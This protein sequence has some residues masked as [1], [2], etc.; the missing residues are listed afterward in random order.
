MKGPPPSPE[1]TGGEASIR[2]Y[3]PPLRRAGKLRLYLDV[4]TYR[5]RKGASFTEERV[6][7]VGVLEDWTPYAPDSAG[8]WGRVK[9]R[10]FTEWELGSERNVVKEFY[11]YLKGLIRARRGG[12]VKSIEVVGF[13]VLRFDIPLL[14]QKGAEYGV[15]SVAELN[16]LWYD[17][18]TRDL[19]QAA[20]PVNNMRFQGLTLG[21]LASKLR[22]AG[23]NIPE[24]HGKGVDVKDWYEKGKY[25]EIIKHLET[26]L[27]TTRVIDLRYW[28]LF[29]QL[30]GATSSATPGS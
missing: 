24:L 4:E 7:A 2:Y 3:C 8:E 21:Y 29:E 20:L 27:K 1:E 9:C 22:E 11:D 10:Y 18:F 30:H 6:I 14:I 19:F 23:F 13:N 12:K 25:G 26:D 16:R 5:P 28:S 17:T 15:G